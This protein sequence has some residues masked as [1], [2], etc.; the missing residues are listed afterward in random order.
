[1]TD[2]R[3]LRGFAEF[4]APA[5][6]STAFTER[7]YAELVTDLHLETVPAGGAA[8]HGTRSRL[9]VVALLAAAVAL[10]LAI[11][12]GAL[13]TLS[14]PS[15]PP[16]PLELVQLSRGAYAHPPAVRFAI[17]DVSG[18]T[19]VA[20]DGK[21]TWRSEFV[22]LT[23]GSYFLYDGTRYGIYDAM[24]RTWAVFEVTNGRSPV[25]VQQRVHLDGGQL[26]G[27]ARHARRGRLRRC[28]GARRRNHPR[29]GRRRDLV[30]PHR[31]ALLRIDRE[32]HL[33]LRASADEGSRFRVTAPGEPDV[34]E[35]TA[36]ELG[37]G[38]DPGGVQLGR[39]RRRP[40]G[41]AR[42]RVRRSSWASGQ[43]AWA[44]DAVDG[45]QVRVPAPGRPMA[46]LFTS[47]ASCDFCRPRYVAFTQAATNPAIAAIV[48]GWDDAGTLAGFL[49]EHPT[50]VPVVPDPDLIVA[51]A[52]GVNQYSALVLIDADGAVVDVVRA[53]GTPAGV[54]RVPLGVDRR[55]SDPDRG[56]FERA[57]AAGRHA[58][59][60]YRDP[61]PVPAGRGAARPMDRPHA[62]RRRDLV[63]GPS[64]PSGRHVAGESG[65]VR[66]VLPR[67]L[68]GGGAHR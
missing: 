6:P 36:F 1:M 19:T 23:P 43:P 35:V 37:G 50:R 34:R 51:G 21:G 32:T 3:I 26:S 64:G 18:A 25:P 16:T 42:S 55:G 11:L 41:R 47:P 67:G 30:P 53:P 58:R 12:A 56:A 61:G 9:R 52:W 27:P 45:T 7:L 63:G 2:D 29:A 20:S 15:V 48:V 60:V 24:V 59:A 13:L 31:D 4:D 54:A 17:L 38:S 44:V 49:S 39:F 28:R 57:L 33:V 8:R 46:I 10:L 14:R 66:R 68:G 62:R 5:R 65:D 40:R 22:D